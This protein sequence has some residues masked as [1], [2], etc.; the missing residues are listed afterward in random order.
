M[1]ERPNYVIWNEIV[2]LGSPKHLVKQFVES[3]ALPD[4]MKKDIADDW[5]YK[6][7][8]EAIYSWL[9]DADI[10]AYYYTYEDYCGD[11]YGLFYKDGKFWTVNGAHCSCMGL[12]GQ[13]DPEET[14]IEVECKRKFYGYDTGDVKG[15]LS[16]FYLP[17]EK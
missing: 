7:A 9:A 4:G 6:E 17:E 5:D 3:I 8:R 10:L 2:R 11:A 14:T 12:E 15:R 1:E 16:N 13:W